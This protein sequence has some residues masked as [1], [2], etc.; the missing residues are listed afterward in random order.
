MIMFASSFY[1]ILIFVCCSSV[2]FPFFALDARQR[3]PQYQSTAERQGKSTAEDRRPF[4]H[5]PGKGGRHTR[6]P[7][8]AEGR[9]QKGPQL[10]WDPPL[11]GP[12][13]KTPTLWSGRQQAAQK[14]L[15]GT[16]GAC[17]TR[18]C[19]TGQA[20]HQN[21]AGACRPHQKTLKREPYSLLHEVH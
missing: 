7:S 18:W 10:A 12:A 21:Q 20:P 11:A 9:R 4:T 2:C 15:Q 1:D 3:P 8:R 19:I 13:S 16:A 6:R 14:R 5:D 17:P